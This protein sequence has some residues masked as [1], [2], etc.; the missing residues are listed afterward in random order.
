MAELYAEK[1]AQILILREEGYSQR[2]IGTKMN[3]SRGA[4][5]RS[6]QRYDLDKS[7]KSKKRSGRPK[8]TTVQTDRLIHRLSCARPFA[9]T[10]EIRSQLPPYAPVSTSTISRRLRHDFSLH[11]RRPAIKPRLSLKNVKDRLLFCNKYKNWEPTDWHRVIFSDECKIQQFS[12]NVIR[13]WRPDGTRFDPKYTVKNVKHSPSVMVW[14]SMSYDG[15]GNLCFVPAGTTIRSTEYIDIL[16]QHLLPIET[17]K[18]FQHD[19]A[20]CHT[21]KVVKEFISLNNMEVLCP[22]PGNSPDIS[23]IENCWSEL[24]KKVSNLNPTSINDLKIKINQVWR[25]D[26]SPDYCKHLIDSMP[27]RIAAVIKAKGQITKY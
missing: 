12:P 4:V 1:R 25:N 14:S 9:P 10:S 26:I 20:T 15:V 19:G 6:I 27:N 7:F 22:W 21:A 11:S 17:G 23:P 24:K 16:S 2:Q 3:V 13:V 18:I 5:R 8:V